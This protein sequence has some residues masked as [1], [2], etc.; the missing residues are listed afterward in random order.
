MT[1]VDDLLASAARGNLDE[2][3]ALLEQGQD[4]IAILSKHENS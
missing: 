3:Q 1:D 4:V 2:V